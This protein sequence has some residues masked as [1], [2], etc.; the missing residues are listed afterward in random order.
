VP[1]GGWQAPIAQQ[2]YQPPGQLASWGSRLGAYLLDALII[3][4]PALVILGL[5]G[6]GFAF[7]SDSD[8]SGFFALVGG[9]ILT[10][11]AF[12]VISLIYAPMLMKREGARNGQTLGKQFVGIRVVRDN[13]Q[14]YDFWSAALREVVVKNLAVGIASSVI[15]ILPWFLNFFWPLWDDEN[16]AL[17]DMVVKSHVVRA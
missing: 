1:P 4:V 12:V 5:F 3:A 17:H 11:L 16:R 6:V 14:P 2:G 8:N 13:G 7:N 15:P 9:A 10:V